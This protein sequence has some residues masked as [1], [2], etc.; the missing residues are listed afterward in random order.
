MNDPIMVTLNLNARLRPLDRGEVFEDPIL[1]KLEKDGLGEIDGGGTYM[2]EGGEPIGSDITFA[3]VSDAAWRQL[4]ALLERLLIPNGSTLLN[5]VTGEEVAIGRVDGLGLYF[6]NTDLAPEVYE[7]YDINDVIHD[8]NELLYG[9]GAMLSYWEGRD[10][11]AL[12]Y[13]G[14]S[15]REMRDIIERYTKEHPLCQKCRIEQI[16]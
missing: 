15:Y 10:W 1:E 13:Y 4:P 7:Q 2:G 14:P 8:L 9:P 11:T 3:L 5:H 6:N 16:A 12:Y